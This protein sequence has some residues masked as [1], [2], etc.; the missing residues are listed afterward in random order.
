MVVA[1]VASVVAV[2]AGIVAVVAGIVGGIT[3]II[4]ARVVAV[5]AL[6]V[7]VGP[8]G[9]RIRACH[10]RIVS[11]GLIFDTRFDV[12]VTDC[13]VEGVDLS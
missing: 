4:V 11:E 8:V 10:L 1:V 7:V 6:I 5:V 3:E 9:C 2:V 12:E 13:F